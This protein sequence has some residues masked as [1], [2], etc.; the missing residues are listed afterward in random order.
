MNATKKSEHS[1]ETVNEE[2]LVLIAEGAFATGKVFFRRFL[3]ILNLLAFVSYKV[4]IFAGL[5]IRAVALSKPILKI[6]REETWIY[7]QIK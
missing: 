7:R 4:F 1:W 6:E 2:R 5:T 3:L